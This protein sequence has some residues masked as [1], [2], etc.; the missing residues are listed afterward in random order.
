MTMKNSSQ[1]TIRKAVAGD[2]LAFRELVLDNSHAMFRLAWRM[3]CDESAAEDIVQEA[4]IKAWR[5]MP[6]F[7]GEAAFYTWLYRIAH[8]VVYDWLRKKKVQEFRG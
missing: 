7:K 6:R 4:F 1:K 5:A 3:T 8:N 2:R